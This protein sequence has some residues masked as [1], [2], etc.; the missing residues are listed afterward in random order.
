[1]W[2]WQAWNE[3]YHLTLNFE[4]TTILNFMTR[5]AVPGLEMKLQQ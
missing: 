3:F 1:M 2:N 5:V 4:L